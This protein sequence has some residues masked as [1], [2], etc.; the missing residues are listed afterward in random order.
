[1]PRVTRVPS[2]AVALGAAI[3]AAVAVPLYEIRL[4]HRG[5]KIDELD[6][7][8]DGQ[9]NHTGTDPHVSLVWLGDSTAAGVGADTA[10]GTLPRQVALALGLPVELKVFAR[11]G[12]RIEGV[13]ADQIPKLAGLESPPEIVLVSVGANDVA[14]LTRRA[15]FCRDYDAMLAAI[16]CPVVVL[17]IPDM[18]AALALAQPLRAIVGLRAR[19]VDRWIRS[20]VARHD[21]AHHIDITTKPTTATQRVADY[22]CPDRYH[23]N[24]VGYGVWAGVVA[25]ALGSLLSATAVSTSAV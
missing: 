6:H 23:P 25:A 11:S 15:D 17:S 14:N 7:V 19:Q 20:C 8:L 4:A 22:L 9:L 10:D 16:S 1:M 5:P 3:T 13:V 12:E 21:H 2:L 24:D 18:S